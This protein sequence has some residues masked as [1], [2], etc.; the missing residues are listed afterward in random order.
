V[1]LRAVVRLCLP[2]LPGDLRPLCLGAGGKCVNCPGEAA[3]LLGL[4][5][6]WIEAQTGAPSPGW[7]LL[8]PESLVP[9]AWLLGRARGETGLEVKGLT[10]AVA[11]REASG[12]PGPLAQPSAQDHPMAP[13]LPPR[14]WPSPLNSVVFPRDR[15][16]EDCLLSHSVA[17]GIAWAAPHGGR[18]PL[19]RSKMTPPL[20]CLLTASRRMAASRS[21]LCCCSRS[22]PRDAGRGGGCGGDCWRVAVGDREGPLCAASL[23]CSGKGPSLPSGSSSSEED[24]PMPAVMSSSSGTGLY[25]SDSEISAAVGRTGLRLDIGTVEGLDPAAG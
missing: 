13:R 24:S 15:S 18:A 10:H 23:S 19:S 2:R 1:A 22:R 21:S 20:F 3:A 11:G 5:R 9:S 17:A 14:A 25:A 16:G 12:E 8:Q 6:R 7:R 4:S